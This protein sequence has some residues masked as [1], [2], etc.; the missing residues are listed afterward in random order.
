MLPPCVLMTER[1]LPALRILVAKELRNKGLSQLRIAELLGVTQ[2]AVNGYLKKRGEEA[3]G[4]L[5]G[6]GLSEEEAHDLAKLLANLS[7]IS[8]VEATF[9]LYHYWSK[10]LSRGQAC[11]EHIAQFRQLATCDVCLNKGRAVHRFDLEEDEVL[12]NLKRA[13]R[14]LES[15]PLFPSLIPEVFTNVVMARAGAQSLEDVA[16]IPGRIA[17]FKGGVKVGG[18]PEFGVSRHMASVLLA[19]LAVDPTKRACL[20]IKYEPRIEGLLTPLGYSCFRTIRG[21][22]KGAMNEDRVLARIRRTVAEKGAVPDVLVDEGD[23]GIEPM[24]YIFAEDAVR[25][26]VKALEIAKAYK[27]SLLA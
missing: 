12:T 9:A 10:L 22:E 15:S 8:P 18:E 3:L 11:N 23:V 27:R 25:A 4:L 24:M 7:L 2:A 17:R 16:G 1:F 14:L 13:V 5:A 6:F 20:N 26:A 21:Q 19:A